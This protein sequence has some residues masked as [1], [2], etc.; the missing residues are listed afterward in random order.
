[1]QTKWDDIVFLLISSVSFAILWWL[2]GRLHNPR[3]ARF[4]WD[5]LSRASA[6]ARGMWVFSAET[7][8]GWEV[9]FIDEH[10]FDFSALFSWLARAFLVVLYLAAL[11]VWILQNVGSGR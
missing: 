1:M 4:L 7:T 5:L 6:L 8:K 2:C 11:L 3:L 9:E 10:P